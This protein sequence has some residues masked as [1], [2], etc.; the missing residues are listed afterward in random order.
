M[1][2]F[3]VPITTKGVDADTKCEEYSYFYKVAYSVFSEVDVILMEL[4]K[5]FAK[6]R[7]Y[8]FGIQFLFNKQLNHFVSVLSIAQ[9]SRSDSTYLNTIV[10]LTGYTFTIMIG[11]GFVYLIG[12]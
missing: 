12:L 2:Y 3:R 10:Y 1:V 8:K 5:E 4:Q 11:C 7:M 6:K 9:V